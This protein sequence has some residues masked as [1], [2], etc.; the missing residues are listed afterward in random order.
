MKDIFNN[1]IA[2]ALLVLLIISVLAI[3]V[4][5]DASAKEIIVQIIT[6][7]GAL[8]TGVG[9]GRGSDQRS[10]DTQTKVNVK[11]AKHEKADG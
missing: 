6:A 2:M 10:T 5:E 11:E 4:L 3:V 8:V 9:I 7:I 1:Q